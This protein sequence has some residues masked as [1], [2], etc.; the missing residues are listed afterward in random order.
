[1]PILI[2]QLRLLVGEGNE[3]VEDQRKNPALWGKPRKKPPHSIPNGLFQP[4]TDGVDFSGT[5]SFLPL[6]ILMT[7]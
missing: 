3:G 1:L 7:A 5:S 2:V 4:E 6:V